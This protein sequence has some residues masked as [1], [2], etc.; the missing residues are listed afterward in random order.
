MKLNTDRF[1]LIV[2]DY[3]HEQVW[4]QVGRDKIWES[5]DVKLLGVILIENCNLIN[6]S[7]RFARK[8]AEE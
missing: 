5:V 6:M 1:H 4:A 8:Q 2:S 3:K 7:R